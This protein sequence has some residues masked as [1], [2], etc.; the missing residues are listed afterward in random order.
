MICI[1]VLMKMANNESSK[2]ANFHVKSGYFGVVLLSF[3]AL[4]ILWKNW[5]NFSI[6]NF[7]HLGLLAIGLISMM[8]YV[9]VDLH[10]NS[11]FLTIIKHPKINPVKYI[12]NLKDVESISVFYYYSRGRP[13]RIYIKLNYNPIEIE[14][15][16]PMSPKKSN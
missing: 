1:K 10:L 11:D 13:S 15:L 12:Y 14:F 6:L 16:M 3:F 9:E 8:Y 5:G 7:I 2:L 4:L